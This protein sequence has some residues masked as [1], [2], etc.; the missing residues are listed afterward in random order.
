MEGADLEAVREAAQVEAKGA[1]RAP[2]KV[3]VRGRAAIEEGPEGQTGSKGA[4]IPA[5]Y[6]RREPRK[7]PVEPMEPQ[8]GAFS[9]WLLMPRRSNL[10]KKPMPTLEPRRAMTPGLARRQ[11]QTLS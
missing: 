2:V 11:L 1:V 4:R 9:N 8:P 7:R 3:P 6:K 10:A 5:A